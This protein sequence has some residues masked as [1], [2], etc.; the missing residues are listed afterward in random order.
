MY[1]ILYLIPAHRCVCRCAARASRELMNER[2]W[3]MRHRGVGLF[4]SDVQ[5]V[6]SDS[7]AIADAA[8]YRPADTSDLVR[9]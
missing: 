2:G 8:A 9:D 3:Q 7:R 5:A 1:N 4:L 6:I